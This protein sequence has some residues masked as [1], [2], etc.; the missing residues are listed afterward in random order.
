MLAI[1]EIRL[2]NDKIQFYVDNASGQSAHKFI[3]TQS[4]TNSGWCTHSVDKSSARLSPFVDKNRF[5]LRD[6]HRRR[7]KTMRKK[8]EKCWQTTRKTTTTHEIIFW[9]VVEYEKLTRRPWLREMGYS[10][11]REVRVYAV[12]ALA[13]YSPF[14][15]HIDCSKSTAKLFTLHAAYT[16]HAHKTT[17]TKD[18]NFIMFHIRKCKQTWR[19]LNLFTLLL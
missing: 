18:K 7:S 8:W 17:L 13:V 15:I 12:L 1:H 4:S 10:L 3:W 6:R 16:T 19:M 9:V 14:R 5:L 11:M 2:R